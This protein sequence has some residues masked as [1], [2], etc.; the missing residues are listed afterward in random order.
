[1]A[2]SDPLAGAKAL[3]PNLSNMVFL[4]PLRRIILLCLLLAPWGGAACSQSASLQA[5]WQ[6]NAVNLRWSG[7][8]IYT[9]V[10]STSPIARGV[11]RRFFRRPRR[12]SAVG[13]VVA[14]LLARR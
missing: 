2:F 10:R 14:A 9:L 11:Q 7:R 13:T 4:A 5:R 12:A 8:G 6:D 1:M 3:P